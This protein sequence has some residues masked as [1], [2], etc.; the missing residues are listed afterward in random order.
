MITIE[1]HGGRRDG[2]RVQFPG[3]RDEL[4]D[5]CFVEHLRCVNGCC[6]LAR[7]WRWDLTTTREGHAIFRVVGVVPR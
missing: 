1:L 3:E 6:N 2:Y 4:L 5:A 7:H